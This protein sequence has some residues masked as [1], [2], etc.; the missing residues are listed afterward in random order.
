MASYNTSLKD[1]GATGSEYPTG[2][3]YLEGEQPVDAWD[4]FLKYHL[5]KDVKNHLIPLTNDR[6]ESGSGTTLPSSQ[7]S[8]HLFADTDDGEYYAYDSTQNQWRKLLYADGDT[9][10]GALDMDGYEIRDS[11][12]TLTLSGD[13]S[14]S[15]LYL[16]NAGIWFDGG[17]DSLI[18]V[19]TDDHHSRYTDSEAQSAV[20]GA[21]IDIGGDA[22]TLDGNHASDFANDVHS[23]SGYVNTG[24]DSMSGDLNMNGNQVQ[25]VT[26]RVDRMQ[27]FYNWTKNTFSSESNPSRQTYTTINPSGH[28]VVDDWDIRDASNNNEWIV[29]HFDDGSSAEVGGGHEG[30][31]GNAI[32]ILEK[33]GGSQYINK[34]DLDYLPYSDSSLTARWEIAGT[35]LTG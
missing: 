7:E 16:S 19:N 18:E 23:H 27:Y 22:D 20:D 21:N 28:L 13:V 12:G 4:N 1:W 35:Q 34:I 29:F 32:S 11:S 3:K 10:S 9:L 17:H 30:G 5:I 31:D 15:R 8:A 26:N 2:Y 33:G 25:N 14:A 6:V 24:G